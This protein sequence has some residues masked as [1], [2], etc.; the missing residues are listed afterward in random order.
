M[1]PNLDAVLICSGP[2]SGFLRF[3]L[4]Y[5]CQDAR[6]FLGLIIALAPDL[7]FLARLNL[8]G[9]TSY[10]RFPKPRLYSIDTFLSVLYSQ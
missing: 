4:N 1:I 10:P 7:P 5:F 2:R 8:K 6:F 3:P 9:F